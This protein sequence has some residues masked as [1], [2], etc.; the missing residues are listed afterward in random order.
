MNLHEHKENYYK[1]E[2]E[3]NSWSN[4]YIIILLMLNV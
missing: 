4:N 3:G 1:P 2:R